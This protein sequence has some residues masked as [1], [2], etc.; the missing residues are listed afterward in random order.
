MATELVWYEVLDF[1][2]YITKYPKDWFYRNG[3]HIDAKYSPV[4][5]PLGLYSTEEKAMEK[6]RKFA[7]EK[8]IPF[9]EN[10]C[11][12]ELGYPDFYENS[13][14]VT[15]FSIG[16]VGIWFNANDEP[17]KNIRDDSYY[18][19]GAFIIKKVM[20]LDED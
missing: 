9:D 12:L 14:N 3:R 8:G 19:T 1:T 18:G 2:S 20:T 13:Y 10:F 17:V 6:L 16:E 5:E 15:C 7:E 4:L 11:K